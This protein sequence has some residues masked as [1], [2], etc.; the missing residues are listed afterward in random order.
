MRSANRFKYWRRVTVEKER[1]S[2]L[3]LGFLAFALVLVLVLS[4]IFV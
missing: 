4:L 1:P 3:T 2:E